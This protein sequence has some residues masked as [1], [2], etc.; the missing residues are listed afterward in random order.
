MSP[1]TISIYTAILVSIS[2]LVILPA[3]KSYSMTFE[4][5]IKF[6]GVVTR[7]GEDLQRSFPDRFNQPTPQPTPEPEPNFPPP[8]TQQQDLLQQYVNPWKVN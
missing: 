6:L 5:I 7:Y 3:T 8:T 2:S 1:K 4:E